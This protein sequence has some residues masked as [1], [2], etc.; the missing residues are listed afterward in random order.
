MSGPDLT[1]AYLLFLFAGFIIIG[2]I[3]IYLGG[4]ISL[5]SGGLVILVVPDELNLNRNII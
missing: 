4:K 1:T 3:I 2:A 5:G